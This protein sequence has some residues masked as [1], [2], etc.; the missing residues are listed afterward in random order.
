[1]KKEISEHNSEI[2]NANKN[3]AK[4]QKELADVSET[5]YACGQ[6]LNE[7]DLEKVKS[8]LKN[9]IK[10]ED[11]AISVIEFALPKIK[12]NLEKIES[13]LVVKEKAVEEIRTKYQNIDLNIEKRRN[14]SNEIAGIEKDLKR[15]AEAK[16]D[17]ENRISSIEKEEKPKL[18]VEALETE[19]EKNKERLTEIA[20]DKSGKAYLGEKLKWWF[21]TG[22]GSNG[23]KSFVF[24]AM[25]SNLNH[26]VKKYVSRFGVAVEFSVDVSKTSKP[27]TTTCFIDGIEVDYK[28]LSGG[29][30]QRVDIALAFAMHDLVTMGTSSF[31]ILIL[32]ELFENL[33]AKGIEIAFDLIRLKAEEDTGVWIVTHNAVIDSLNTKTIYLSK[34]KKGTFIDM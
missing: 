14:K 13:E 7:A 12:T 8:N 26:F 32:D 16:T 11:D 24:N 4:L 1:M 27:F 21:S 9:E 17:I 6:A 2:A 33:D 18:D 5:C 25:L 29:E 3:K 19:I 34:N 22:F 23:L 28:E 30:K 31:N 15:F 20:E 10:K